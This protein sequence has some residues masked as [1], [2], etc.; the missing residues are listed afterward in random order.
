MQHGTR[1]RLKGK[2][3]SGLKGFRKGDQ[4]VTIMVETPKELS[5]KEKELFETLKETLEK[6]NIYNVNKKSESKEEENGKKG[7]FGKMKDTV[8]DFFSDEG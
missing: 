5:D 6:T 7:F 1:F 2:G 8:N 4:Y 3:I